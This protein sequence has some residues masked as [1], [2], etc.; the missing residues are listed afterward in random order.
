VKRNYLPI[1]ALL[2]ALLALSACGSDTITNP[3]GSGWTFEL[4]TSGREVGLH[5]SL[6]T[7]SDG[8][9][10]LAFF[11]RRHKDLYL[12]RRESAGEWSISE[13]DTVGWSG[14][15]ITL[16]I[17]SNDHLH[18]AYQDTWNRRLRYAF[19]DGSGWLLNSPGTYHTV[20]DAPTIIERSDGIHMVE[21][22]TASRSGS[23]AG[24]VNYWWLAP[25]GWE[26]LSTFSLSYLRP[27]IGFAWGPDGPVIAMIRKDHGGGR[28]VQSQFS[29]VRQSA[30][31][32]SGPWTAA[33]LV[34]VNS[35]ESLKYGDRPIGIGFD[36]NDVAHLVYLGLGGVL[37]DTG[38]ADID[39]GV[40]NSQVI[41][42]TGPGG[43]L[44]LTY[45]KG[46]TLHLSRFV[47][48]SWEQMGRVVDLDPDGRYDMHVDTDGNIHMCAYH[49]PAQKLWYGRWEVTP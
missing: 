10:H 4:L 35:Y 44:W 40:R 24:S 16:F 46:T 38:G 6:A 12:A 25:G 5:S 20:G 39:T 48:G 3:H 30:P 36:N 7:T 28:A 29:I 37:K 31:D 21:M 33:Y 32:G 23:R 2:I 19:N 45:M 42:R 14:E 34:H 17:D 8:T 49:L 11:D 9:V 18:L 26:R 1:P 41:M 43:E 13:I 27:F 15:F 22:N 47:T